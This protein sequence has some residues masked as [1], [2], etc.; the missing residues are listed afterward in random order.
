[1]TA[2]SFAIRTLLPEDQRKALVVQYLHAMPVEDGP[3]A[4][5]HLDLI[6]RSLTPPT[7]SLRQEDL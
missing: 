1:M 7:L 6:L 4:A 2:V 5:M 3:D